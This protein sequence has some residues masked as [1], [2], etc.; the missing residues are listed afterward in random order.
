LTNVTVAQMDKGLADF[1]ADYR[2]LRIHVS[3]AIWPVLRGISGAPKEQVEGL[4][5]NLRKNAAHN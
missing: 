1:Y 3:D 2:N 4:I 5:E